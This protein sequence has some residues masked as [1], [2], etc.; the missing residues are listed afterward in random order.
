VLV[1]QSIS[2][3]NTSLRDELLQMQRADLALRHVLAEEG[4]LS[5]R[6]NDRMAA[7]HRQ[8]NA[9]L[10]DII[11][12]HGWPGLTLVGEEGAEA[13]WL[14]LQHAILD[15]EL[16]RGAVGL[17]ERSVQAGE[18]QPWQLALLVDR[19]RTLEGQPQVYGSQHDWDET[20]DMSPLRIEDIDRVDA[21]RASV[22]L[23]P[24]AQ[25]TRRLRARAASEGQRPPTDPAGHRKAAQEWARAV[26]WSR[27]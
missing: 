21:R 25:T 11:A 24:L 3:T 26:G 19:I 12:E 13:A 6:Y 15:P 10:R 1:R 23:E 7:L 2:M 16:M 4:A 20:G 14:V 17:V 22:G 27:P 8:H 5:G 18:T 9:R